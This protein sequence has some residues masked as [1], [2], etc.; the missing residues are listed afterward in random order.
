MENALWSSDDLA[1]FLNV[2][3]STVR[4]WRLNHVGPPAM[5]LGRHVRY[6]PRDVEVWLAQRRTEDEGPRESFG[7]LREQEPKRLRSRRAS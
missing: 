4:H 1:E 2:P 3:L 7:G 6:R 5:K